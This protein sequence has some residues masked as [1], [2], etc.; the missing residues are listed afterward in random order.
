MFITKYRG[1]KKIERKS[2]NEI[3]LQHEKAKK[4]ENKKM[5]LHSSR[6]GRSNL[7]SYFEH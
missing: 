7:K 2:R 4:D 5:A 6:N 3:G 1:R